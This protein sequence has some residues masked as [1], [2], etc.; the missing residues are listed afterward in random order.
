[1][2]LQEHR[3]HHC[4]S[5]VVILD[6]EQPCLRLFLVSLPLDILAERLS[7]ILIVSSWLD[8][9]RRPHP[10]QTDFWIEINQ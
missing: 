2:G 10:M 3:L 5:C 8:L 1:M 4:H 7:Q 6:G 9:S